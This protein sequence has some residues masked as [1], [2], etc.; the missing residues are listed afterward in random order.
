MMPNGQRL[1]LLHLL[2]AG[3]RRVVGGDGVNR[4]G[5]DALDHRVR[6]RT[7]ERSGGFIL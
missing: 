2:A 1:E 6:R 4:A 7:R 5:D 3:M